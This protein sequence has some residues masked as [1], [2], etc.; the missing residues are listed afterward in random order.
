M[1]LNDSAESVISEFSARIWNETV[2][3]K[4]VHLSEI[5]TKP[6]GRI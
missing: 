1:I 6:D 3:N 4:Y 2:I 5:F